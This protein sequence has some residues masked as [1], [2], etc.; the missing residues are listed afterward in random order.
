MWAACDDEWSANFIG[1]NVAQ[2]NTSPGAVASILPSAN[3]DDRDPE[4]VGYASVVGEDA[5]SRIA[6]WVGRPGANA[7][8]YSVFRREA[9]AEFDL[10]KH[11]Y[12]GGDWSL[13][14]YALTKGEFVC[15]PGAIGFRK[16]EEGESRDVVRLFDSRRRHVVEYVLP[17]SRFGRY[18]IELCGLHLDIIGH[19]LHLNFEG[20]RSYWPLRL[21][22]CFK[23]W[24]L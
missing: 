3:G 7:R 22:Q 1:D 16:R 23:E 18:V 21:K 13:I 5:R 4:R 8:F 9:L 14:A 11:D 12:L 15:C 24:A 20:L 6:R 2:L 19:L 10:R 17:Y